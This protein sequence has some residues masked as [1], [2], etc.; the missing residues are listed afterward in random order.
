MKHTHYRTIAYFIVILL[1]GLIPGRQ[2]LYAYSLAG[3]KWASNPTVLVNPSGGP[4]GSLTAFQSAMNTWTAVSTS[5]FSFVYGGTTTSHDYSQNDGTNIGDFGALSGDTILGQTWYWY[6]AGDNIIDADIRLNSAKSWSTDGTP[7]TNDVEIVAMHEYGHALGL[8]H[9]SNSD[10]LMYP[11]YHGQD[12]LHQDDIDAVSSLYPLTGSNILSDP[13]LYAVD[14][15][16]DTRDDLVYIDTRGYVYYT[17]DLSTWNLIGTNK[18]TMVV[19]GD[20]NSDNR[21]DLAGL[22]VNQYCVYNLQSATGSF[23]DWVKSGSNKFSSMI[24]MDLDGSGYEKDL[25]GINLN[26]YAVYTDNATGSTDWT[27]SGSNKFTSLNSVDLSDHGTKRD[28]TGINLNQYVVYTTDITGSWTRSG[29]NRFL[30]VV[31][32]NL[33]DDDTAEESALAGINLNRYVVYSQD[34]TGGGGWTK[35]GSNKYLSIV[36]CD[37]DGNGAKDDLAGINLSRYVVYSD[38][39]QGASTWERLGTNSFTSLVCGNFDNDTRQDDLAAV[40]QNGHVL[41]TL[42]TGDPSISFGDWIKIEKP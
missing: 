32:A 17:T 10:A 28:L 25:V 6:D 29:S 13:Y 37:F 27:K 7:G 24:S 38:D 42:Q 20:F 15:D 21:T 14:L 12:G 9:S 3:V 11:T 1:A 2:S 33:A 8:A 36:A 18:C 39:V 26:Q 19:S 16:N 31:S 5:Y 22:N 4:S 35:S 23:D 30:R 34:P 40:N 41:Y